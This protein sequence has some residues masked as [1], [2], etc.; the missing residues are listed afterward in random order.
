MYVLLVQTVFCH[1]H[2]CSSRHWPSC[3]APICDKELWDNHKACGVIW[4]SIADSDR[5]DILDIQFKHI[6]EEFLQNLEVYCP[7]V[8][9][10]TQS[11]AEYHDPWWCNV[12]QFLGVLYSALPEQYLEVHCHQVCFITLTVHRWWHWFRLGLTGEAFGSYHWPLTIL[13]SCSSF[14]KHTMIYVRLTKGLWR[15]LGSMIVSWCKMGGEWHIGGH[16]D[17]NFR[18]QQ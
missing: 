17:R 1:W 15:A 12:S 13:L 2:T 4:C 6:R 16:I 9:D 10:P 5:G 7:K 8:D 11:V 18:A 14:R 3:C